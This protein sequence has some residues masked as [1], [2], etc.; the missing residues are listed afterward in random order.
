MRS[1]W[2]MFD[3]IL[4]MAR[5]D[6]RVR[7]V[8]LNGSRVD[9]D[10]ARDIFQDYDL[11][12]IVTAMDEF[13]RNRDWIGRF[14]ELT[15]LQTPDES[16]LFPSER[17][18][19]AFLMLFEDGN[20][21][22]LTLHPVDQM[23]DFRPEGL[24]KLLLDKDHIL[25]PLPVPDNTDRRTNPPTPGQYADC[26]NEF[27]W[28]S[29]YVAKGLWR[30]ELP[31]AKSVYDQPLRNMLTLMLKWHIGVQTHFSADAGKF[32]R[33]FERHLS[34]KHWETYVQTYPD[35]E[36]DNMWQALFILCN[37]FREIAMEVGRHFGYPYPSDDD[38]R[39]TRYLRRV[40]DLPPSSKRR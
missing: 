33:Y 38:R 37:L 3:L 10:A 32:G 23:E 39:V 2:Q 13:V 20:R 12:F 21:I 6:E 31:Y 27:W 35:G 14:G 17:T 40:R 34:P 24:S 28:V 29:T 9:P 25:D 11:V 16:A 22:D 5:E 18:G 4:Q 26:C 1:E 30:R 7:A 15:I 36:Y 8:I 19:F